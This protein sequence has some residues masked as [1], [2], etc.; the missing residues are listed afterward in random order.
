MSQGRA[1]RSPAGPAEP[2][3]PAWR[4]AVVLLAALAT[5]ALVARLG[6]WQLDRAAQKVAL[7]ETL[8]FA[9]KHIAIGEAQRAEDAAAEAVTSEQTKSAKK[10]ATR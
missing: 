7:Q 3:E 6:F 1:D 8:D 4:K 5:I 2:S 10:P 9:R